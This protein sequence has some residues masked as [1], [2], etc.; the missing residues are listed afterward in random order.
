MRGGLDWIVR[1]RLASGIVLFVY[2]ATHLL[3]HAFGVISLD[4]MEWGRLYFLAAWRNPVGTA[5]LYGSLVVH[6]GLVLY[7][8]YRRR[9]LRMP[10][11]EALQIVA[12]LAIPPL[13]ALHVVGNRGLHE[14]HDVNDMYAYVLIAILSDPFEGFRLMVALLVTWFHG[15]IGFHFWLKLKPWYPKLAPW[16]LSIALLWPA[17]ALAGVATAL[18]EVIYLLETPLWIGQVAAE[19]NFPSDDSVA[20]ALRTLSI[21]YWSQAG[22][23]VLV[24]ALRI[25]RQ[26]VARRANSLTI[27]YPGGRKVTVAPGLSV[28]E[29]SRSA[30]IPH[31]S[32]CGGRGR[33]STCRVRIA[34]GL[35]HLAPASE[36]EARVLKR[37]GTP[38]NVRLA[39][40]IRPN[41]DVTV[42]PLL[43]PTAQPADGHRRP[44]Y[45]Q[46]TEREIA[47]LFADMRAFT[48]F[49]EKKLPYDVVFVLNQ[50]FR[51][52]GAPIERTG[53]QLD[54]FIGDGVM[55]L[56]GVRGGV[57][58]GCRDALRA[59]REM[60]AA[61]NELNETLKDDLPEPMRI[62]IGIHT[63]AVIVGEMGYATA[64]SVTAIG[65]AVNTASRL[66]TSN[67]EFHSQLVVSAEVATH[68]RVD[69]SAF[70][71]HSLAV[72]GRTEPMQVFVIEDAGVLPEIPARPARR[73]AASEQSAPAAG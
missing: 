37:V 19:I 2:V 61:L 36:E 53:G 27:T 52:M 17:F 18:K 26:L 56:F 33:C 25:G 44:A 57:Q 9:T 73:G 38:A 42:T 47:I 21:G 13:L 1:V 32:V 3:N 29:A 59:A 11:R 30:G 60:A 55:A 24:L 14:F 41:Q 16:L 49:S 7:T 34:H 63:G 62:G 35:E 50:Y 40:Q 48:K 67:K 71:V 65:D 64:R 45:L 10:L 39:C 22:L 28:L 72:R 46:G 69:L 58:Q 31:A 54:K 70:P 4:A 68:A 8:I 66:E 23:L 5:L 20:W 43:A 15:C 6:L 51:A 12:G